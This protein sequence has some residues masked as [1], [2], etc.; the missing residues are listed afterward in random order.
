MLGYPHDVEE[1]VLG[2]GGL[3]NSMKSG[4]YLIDHTTSSPDLAERIYKEAK[5]KGILSWDAPV[6]GGDVGAREGRLVVM[7]GG[8]E[9]GFDKVQPV[10]KL[11][12][13]KINLLGAAGKGQHTKMVNQIFIANTMV[14]LVEGLLYAKTAGLDSAAVIELLGGGAAGSF[15]LNVLGPRILKRDFEPGFYVEHFVKD[16]GIA[17]KES[18]KMGIKL[19]GLELASKLYNI[20]IE[21]G[22]GRKGTQGLYLALE[23]LNNIKNN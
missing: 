16:M 6:S 3:L 21:D 20:L 10:I 17:L 18:E 23:K 1:M 14:G 11:F 7:V 8:Q 22:L 15:S 19:Q 9:E 12:S 2:T 5:G 13:S 4:S